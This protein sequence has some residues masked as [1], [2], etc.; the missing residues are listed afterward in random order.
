MSNF[1]QK[2]RHLDQ[3]RRLKPFFSQ[4]KFHAVDVYK[5]NF[6]PYKFLIEKKYFFFSI[7][8]LVIISSYITEDFGPYFVDSNNN[9]TSLVTNV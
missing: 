1:Y 3:K 2:F 4:V 6:W 9:D 5:G 8:M 7:L